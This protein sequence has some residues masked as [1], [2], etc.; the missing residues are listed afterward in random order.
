MLPYIFTN[1]TAALILDL[2]YAIWFLPELIHTYTHRVDTTSAADDRLSGLG[3]ALGIWVGI[4]LA[5]TLAPEPHAVI[6]WHPALLFALGITLMVTGVAFRWYAV[7][8]LGKYFSFQL[9]IQPGQTVVEQG[10]Y[11]WIRHPSYTGSLIT[12]FG[13]GLVFTNWLSLLA[14]LIAGFIGYS[15]RVSVEEQI[16]IKALGEPYRAYMQRTKRFIPFVY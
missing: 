2:A 3:V 6:L 14:I 7:A 10:P 8:M 4:F 16:L 1:H 11:R 5:Y 9:A 13:L 12:M 15:Y